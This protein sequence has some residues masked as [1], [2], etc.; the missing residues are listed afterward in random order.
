MSVPG[1]TRPPDDGLDDEAPP[2]RRGLGALLGR[3]P[4]KAGAG[5][6]RAGEPKPAWSVRGARNG[7]NG[8]GADADP[9][10]TMAVRPNAQLAAR[11][12]LWALVALGALGGL[13]GL[14]RPSTPAVE[15]SDAS[16]SSRRHPARGRRLRRAGGHHLGRRPRAT[17]PRRR[18]TR[19]T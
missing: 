4:R 10:R 18:S 19:S 5:G 12:G 8:R 3:G 14:L 15:P 9:Q 6:G 16:G 13:V 1:L 7:R 17:G 2:P 11:V